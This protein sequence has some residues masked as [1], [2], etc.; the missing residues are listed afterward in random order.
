MSSSE[1]AF[2]KIVKFLV[3]E[4]LRDKG[5]TCIRIGLVQAASG[6]RG[7]TLKEW[8]RDEEPDRFQ[9]IDNFEALAR[10][11]L[12]IADQNAD[13]IGG[14]V[15]RFVVVTTQAHG[16]GSKHAFKRESD[17]G[18]EDGVIPEPGEEGPTASGMLSQQMR[19]NEVYMRMQTGM[20]QSILSTLSA[21]NR[22]LAEDNRT[23]RQ[24]KV[25]QFNELEAARS[26]NDERTLAGQL[27]VQEDER[28]THMLDGA[29][30]LIPVLASKFLGRGVATRRG[31]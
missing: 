29:L 8:H 14:R 13:S 7:T 2:Q 24:E 11:I 9:G 23:L 5:R 4:L 18:S 30:K 31:E 28:K 3:E 26:R 27:A 6:Y 15:C 12:Q 22:E 17:G 16:G 19:H 1:D 10:D 21:Q 25:A 20:V